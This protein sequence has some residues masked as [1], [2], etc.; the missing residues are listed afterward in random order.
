MRYKIFTEL[1]LN[2]KSLKNAVKLAARKEDHL[3]VFTKL[4]RKTLSKIAF[5]SGLTGKGMSVFHRVLAGYLLYKTLPKN[6]FEFRANGLDEK[7]VGYIVRP[8]VTSEKFS[9]NLKDGLNN[10]IVVGIEN[11]KVKNNYLKHVKLLKEMVSEKPVLYEPKPKGKVVL[12]VGDYKPFFESREWSN[13]TDF[14]ESH[15]NLLSSSLQGESMLNLLVDPYDYSSVK[16]L[17]LKHS[18]TGEV[19]KVVAKRVSSLKTHK[20]IGLKEFKNTI[21]AA[22]RGVRTPPVIGWVKHGSNVYLLFKKV[23][24]PRLDQLNTRTVKYA[25]KLAGVN[26]TEELAKNK[27]EEVELEFEKK[28]GEAE[29]K[30]VFLKDAA[31]RNAFFHFEKTESGE[32]KPVITFI[33]FEHVK[34]LKKQTKK[35]KQTQKK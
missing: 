8:V 32:I 34:F 6:F 28:I 11:S 13:P 19:L 24:A 21:K 30:G 29:E 1:E 3:P 16:E 18:Q 35:M 4:N 31:K 15:S 12:N 9:E 26:P 17:E 27:I 23:E 20:K 10:G 14:I 22:L 25:L 7:E 2:E 33:D 5:L